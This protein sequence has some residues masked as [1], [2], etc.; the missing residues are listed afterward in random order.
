ME[1]DEEREDSWKPKPLAETD[2]CKCATCGYTWRRGMDGSHLCTTLLRAEI[3]RLRALI[4][5][6]RDETPLGH[7]PHMIAHEVDELLGRTPPNTGAQ[8][9]PL[10]DGQ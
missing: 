2:P 7:Q 4:A 10:R 8:Q 1:Y 3:T 5:R 9:P 6:Y